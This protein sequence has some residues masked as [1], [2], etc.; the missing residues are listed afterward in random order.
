MDHVHEN[1]HFPTT[2]IAI[3]HFSPKLS[4]TAMG[5]VSDIIMLCHL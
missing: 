1:C 3:L 4:K 2:I 5:I